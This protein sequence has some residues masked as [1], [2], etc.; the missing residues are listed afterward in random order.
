MLTATKIPYNSLKA[1]IFDYGNTLIRFGQRELERVDSAMIALLERECGPVDRTRF[2][3]LRRAD[4]LAPYQDGNR[5]NEMPALFR[6]HV[7]ELYR[8]QTSEELLEAMQTTWLDSFVDAI[9][10]LPWTRSVLEQLRGRY[11]LALLSNYPSGEAIRASVKRVGLDAYLDV[12]VTSGDV[13][14]VK[15]HPSMFQTVLAQLGVSPAEALHVGDNW[16]ADVQG[17]KGS[18]LW[19]CLLTQFDPPER[20]EPKTG[21]SKP[22]LVIE[23][24]E[25]LPA[26]LAMPTQSDVAVKAPP[27][28]GDSQ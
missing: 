12:I 23:H 3:E 28:S 18:G 16:L 20:F 9:E 8:R 25:E 1:I 4:R 24:L 19:A 22:D 11:K 5:E 13:G 21:D 6:A 26:V 10:P 14:R 2:V 27:A 7:R 15:P 17:A